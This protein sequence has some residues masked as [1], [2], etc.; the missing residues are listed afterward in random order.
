MNQG[1]RMASR[2][3]GRGCYIQAKVEQGQ[4]IEV[5]QGARNRHIIDPRQL[6]RS[7]LDEPTYDR[8]KINGGRAGSGAGRAAS[9]VGWPAYYCGHL[10]QASAWC[11]LEPSR[12]IFRSFR[13]LNHL[14]SSVCLFGVYDSCPRSCFL[15]KSSCSHIFTKA[16]GTHQFKPLFLCLVMELNIYMQVMLMVYNWC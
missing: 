16:R 2:E 13:G 6:P 7:P 9:L 8:L 15:D 5:E 12:V 11:P 3:G 4:E 10:A 1:F 14:L